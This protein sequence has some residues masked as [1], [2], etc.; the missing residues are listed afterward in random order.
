LA[1]DIC[2]DGFAGPAGPA[3]PDRLDGPDDLYGP[4]AG[5][6]LKIELGTMLRFRRLMEWMPGVRTAISM[7]KG[8][9]CA[10]RKDMK[11]RLK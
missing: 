5:Y 11:W 2:W 4:D 6:K 10:V 8:M 1:I 9:K 7:R 3:G